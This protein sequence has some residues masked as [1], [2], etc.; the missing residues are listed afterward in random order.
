MR[1]IVIPRHVVIEAIVKPDGTHPAFTFKDL[2]RAY[3]GS[4]KVVESDQTIG[5]MMEINEAFGDYAPG[6]VVA[7]PD[8]QHEFLVGVMRAFKHNDDIKMDLLPLLRAITSAA[9][10]RPV[11]VAEKRGEA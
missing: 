1:H 2:V 4:S 3:A 10:E 6:T 11:P 8:E 9:K 5:W 7:L